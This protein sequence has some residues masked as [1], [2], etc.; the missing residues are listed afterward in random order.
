MDPMTNINTSESITKD[1][2]QLAFERRQEF[3][4]QSFQDFL[5]EDAYE[6]AF[7]Y[8]DPRFKVHNAGKRIR[9]DD[10]G[11]EVAN[12]EE[13]E[14]A[15][16]KVEDGE[17]DGE[18]HQKND[19]E[20]AEAAAL[21]KNENAQNLEETRKDSINFDYVVGISSLILVSVITFGLWNFYKHFLDSSNTETQNL[22]H[23]QIIE[24][25]SV[26]PS[27][28]QEVPVQ[29]SMGR[30]YER[31]KAEYIKRKQTQQIT[32]TKAISGIEK[33]SKQASPPTTPSTGVSTRF[34]T[35]TDEVNMKGDPSEMRR[36][37]ALNKQGPSPVTSGLPRHL[38]IESE[39]GERTAE[40]VFPSRHFGGQ[41]D[42]EQNLQ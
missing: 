30:S 23:S 21:E 33:P 40:F 18:D 36:A 20:A 27:Q 17:H 32:V 25:A 11:N 10:D 13:D 16:Y 38:D 35:Q 7:L 41:Q 9:R 24:A 8:G 14:E 6:E 31:L 15:E 2:K 37:G 5:K 1:K 42:P 28:K 34:G 12:T 4:K 29:N 3:D 39:I 26:T 19:E 22:I